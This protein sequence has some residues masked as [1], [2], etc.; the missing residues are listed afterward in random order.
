M[1]KYFLIVLVLINYSFSSESNWS[2]TPIDK[3]INHNFRKMTFREPFLLIPYDLKIGMF[4]YGGPNY[5]KNAIKGNFDLN[6]NPI[7]LDNQDINNSFISS[8]DL[9]TG[10]FIEVDIM[11]YNIL[12][13]LYHQNLI[14]F[15]IGAGAR[16]SNILSNPVAPIY[17]ND[18][19]SYRFRPTI[20][21]GFFNLSF[22]S[23]FSSKFYLYSYY[24]FGLTYI[25][26]YESL[27]QQKYIN[28]SGFNENLSLGYKYVINRPNLPYN[29]AIGVELR[30]GRTYI[31]KIYDDKNETP[32]IGLDMNTIG[33]FL[34]F[35]TLFGGKDT[36]GD[37][38]FQLMLDKDYI[39]AANK[40]K[41]FLNIY[42]YNF[43]FNRAKKMLNFC[44]TQIPYQ[45]FDMATKF[46]NE[47]SYDKAL[48]NFNKAEQTADPALILE[49][50]SYKRDIAQELINETNKNLDIHTFF[51]SIKNL[52]KA[53]TISPYLWPET[54]KIEA[55]ILIKKGDILKDLN[56]YSESIDFYQQAFELDP[57]LFITINDKYTE[58]VSYILND[59]ND[60]NNPNELKLVKEYLETIIRLKPKYSESLSKYIIQIDKML[61]NYDITIT[62]LN[63]KQYVEQRR[64]KTLNSLIKEIK[65]GMNFYEIE[66]ILG[67]PDIIKKDKEYDL[68]I[69]N[70]S[71]IDFKTYFFKDY[72]LV[73]ID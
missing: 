50:E 26:I 6:S 12:E 21:D 18:N 45:Y 43:R 51:S 53:R 25:S 70:I 11:K 34:T 13:K 48:Q 44:Y 63:L 32:I 1:S 59:I 40:F 47:G 52:N 68:W 46:F 73:K 66:F 28:G 33:L 61:K 30:S 22:V 8:S 56:N 36:K 7:K 31:N 57:S 35:G 19:Q 55:K 10:F 24:S 65:L 14:D 42:S 54:D 64:N 37:Q 2:S 16:Y 49:I 67:E 15:H 5:F 29:Y 41:Q 9:R 71:N 27:S 69:Y 17:T 62:K 20:F 60:T 39:N 72:I 4:S 58:L 23:Q 38:A 3:F